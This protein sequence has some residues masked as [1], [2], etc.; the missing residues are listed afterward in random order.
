FLEVRRTERVH[1]FGSRRIAGITRAG[2]VVSFEQ[3]RG[4]IQR[5]AL[6]IDIQRLVSPHDA[7]NLPQSWFT[8][9]TRRPRSNRAAPK[10]S[11]H[12]GATKI[13][14]ETWWIFDLAM[15]NDK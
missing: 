7:I 5:L 6:D 8:T 4:D 14:H 15:T 10:K 12:E 11:H 2:H 1:P 13:H 9:E 3:V